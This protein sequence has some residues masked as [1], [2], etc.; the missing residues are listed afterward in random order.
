MNRFLGISICWLL[1]RHKEKRV[2][3]A[4]SLLAIHGDNE[5]VSVNYNRVCSRCGRTRL[6]KRRKP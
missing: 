5:A 2:S 6:A 4:V 1:R 3:P